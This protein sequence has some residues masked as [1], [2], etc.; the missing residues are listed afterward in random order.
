MDIFQPQRPWSSQGGVFYK[1]GSILSQWELELSLLIL[2][3]WGHECV[4]HELCVFDGLA[5]KMRHLALRRKPVM[6]SP[7]FT[8]G[9]G[10]FGKNNNTGIYLD[11]R[12]WSLVTTQSE[13]LINASW[14]LKNWVMR[15]WHPNEEE[16]VCQKKEKE[17]LV[18]KLLYI[19]YTVRLGL[20][21]ARNTENQLPTPAYSNLTSHDALSQLCWLS[22]IACLRPRWLDIHIIR[23]KVTVPPV[24]STKSLQDDKFWPQLS[25]TCLRYPY[26]S[27][28][29]IW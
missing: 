15:C 28:G 5:K 1:T 3:M 18:F 24:L 19:V 29:Q 13:E 9:N 14:F 12:G 23:K 26:Q 8:A 20:I 6:V 25:P 11:R 4:F 16:E 17:N 10:L 27:V 7:H 21:R 22:W 2:L